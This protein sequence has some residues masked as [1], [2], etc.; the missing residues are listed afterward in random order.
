[1]IDE[2]LKLDLLTEKMTLY[3]NNAKECLIK[4]NDS[5]D[6]YLSLYAI[7]NNIY[8]TYL[9]PAYHLKNY[10][11]IVN[12][13]YASGLFNNDL[14]RHKTHS[15]FKIE[16]QEILISI[17]SLLDRL[18]KLLSIK[19]KGIDINSTFG[20]FDKVKNKGRGLM[21]YAYQF[22]DK[23]EYFKRLVYEY[24]SWII[25]AV[26]PRDKVVHY[27]DLPIIYRTTF[28]PDSPFTNDDLTIVHLNKNLTDGV[29]I[30]N[31]EDVDEIAYDI[32]NITE[33]VKK[34]YNLFDYTIETLMKK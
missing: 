22:S 10:S 15:L 9:A 25:K 12:D 21:S 33:F 26:L 14:R 32:D 19:Y 18:V 20:R 28:N 6:Y 34:L 13:P 29:D 4:Q 8:P 11:K 23:D 3:E 30:E 2:S 1:M 27:N 17:K 24:E 7:L 31:T 5:F 16:F